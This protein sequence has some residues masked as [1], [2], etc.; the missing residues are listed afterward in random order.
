MILR[1]PVL[2]LH[3]RAPR[4]WPGDVLVLLACGS[5]LDLPGRVGQAR[6]FHR[7]LPGYAPTPLVR[8]PALAAELGVGR[9]LVKDESYRL[10]LPAFKVLGASWACH[11]AL[12]GSPGARR[13]SPRPTATT[14]ARSPGSPRTAAS[15]RADLRARACSRRGRRRSRTRARRW[16]GWTATT[17]PR[18]GRSRFA[19]DRPGRALVQDTA[20][21]G[22][23]RV[24]AWIVEG[25]P[26]CSPRSTTSSAR[27]P[28][29]SPS[30]SEWGRS[31]KPSCGTTGARLAAA[32]RAVGRAGHRGMRRWRA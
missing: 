29:W 15:G 22:Y 6:S 1:V 2:D 26:R 18:S 20:W 16:C 28:T 23:E 3:D 12:A 27:R 14:A 13:W 17:T 31:R 7:S 19:A 5:R 30:R 8:V 25:Y 9:V 24:P 10:G 4:R 32:G 11:R 21:D